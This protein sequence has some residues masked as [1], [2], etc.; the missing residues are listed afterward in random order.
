MKRIIDTSMDKRFSAQVLTSTFK[1]VAVSDV[2]NFPFGCLVAD[3]ILDVWFSSLCIGRNTH[4]IPCT[5]S[6]LL[7]F[8][9]CVWGQ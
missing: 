9:L 3:L 8:T 4:L 5:Q 1:T 2:Q 6:L 7:Y